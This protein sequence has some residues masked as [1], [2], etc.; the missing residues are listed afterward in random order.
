MS[1]G[2]KLAEKERQNTAQALHDDIVQTLLQMNMQVS[3]CQKYLEMDAHDMLKA[4]LINLSENIMVAS[5]QARAVINDLRPPQDLHL[6]FDK[7]VAAQI[8]IHLER[9]GSP[10][11][12]IHLG[13]GSLSHEQR[14][15]VIRILQEAL[16]NIRKHAQAPLITVNTELSADTC[17]LTIIDDGKGFDLNK[18][19]PQRGAGIALMTARAQAMDATFAIKSKPE[20][21]TLIQVTLPL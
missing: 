18:L 1:K 4:E 5:R 10:V 3:I 8:E 9:G 20:H 14:L 11:N 7:M 6:P 16:A 13:K 17:Q 19:P 12:Y 2:L 21:G 15:S